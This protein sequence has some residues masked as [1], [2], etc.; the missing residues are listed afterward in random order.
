MRNARHLIDIYTKFEKVI[1]F[2]EKIHG[3]LCNFFQ[4]LLSCDS[5]IW[6]KIFDLM[7]I[8]KADHLAQSLVYIFEKNDKTMSMIKVFYYFIFIIFKNV[9]NY[10]F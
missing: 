6:A 5:N 9:L 1:E 10:I 2:S 8:T 3:N 7:S 4:L